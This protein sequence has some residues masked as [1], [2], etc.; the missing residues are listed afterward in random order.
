M[1]SNTNKLKTVR[2]NKIRKA[3]KARKRQMRVHGTT[4]PFPVHPAVKDA[5]STEKKAAE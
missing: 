3:G 1:A 5:E 2:K 4:P